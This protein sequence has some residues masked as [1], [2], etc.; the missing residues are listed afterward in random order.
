MGLSVGNGYSNNDELTKEKFISYALNK[1]TMVYKT[2]DIG[3]YL[4]DGK[5]MYLAQKDN[6]VKLNGY[7]IE[8]DK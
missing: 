2:G 6:Q 3:E 4:L 8:L 5:I 1:S 7:R